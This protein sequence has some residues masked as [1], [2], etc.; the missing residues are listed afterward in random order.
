M[1]HTSA[2]H[3]PAPTEILSPTGNIPQRLIDLMSD[4]F[5]LL[6]MIQR[7]QVP[8]HLPAFS[9]AI[10]QFFSRIENTA[11]TAGIASEDIH[12]AKYAFCATF[13]ELILS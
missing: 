3:I 10:K 4:G 9:T 7:R 11:T 8:E 13:D 2:P 1:T 6:L 12:A 5:Y